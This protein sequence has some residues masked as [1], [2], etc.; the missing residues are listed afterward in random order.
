MFDYRRVMQKAAVGNVTKTS[1]C[2]FR[3]STRGFLINECVTWCRHW[4]DKNKPQEGHQC[5]THRNLLDDASRSRCFP[6][7]E[8]NDRACGLTIPLARCECKNSKGKP[9]N[10]TFRWKVRK[11]CTLDSGPTKYPVTKFGTHH[12][13]STNHEMYQCVQVDRT[14]PTSWFCLAHSAGTCWN[15]LCTKSRR[16]PSLEAQETRFRARTGMKIWNNLFVK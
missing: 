9:K 12:T 14:L 8:E 13:D 10:D 1:A 15:H 4:V 11:Q 3:R 2:H 16:L 6:T 5:S 7:I